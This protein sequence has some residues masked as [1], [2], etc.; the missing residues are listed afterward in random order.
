MEVDLN[1]TEDVSMY[2]YHA[3]VLAV[4]AAAVL[5]WL[6]GWAWYGGIFKSSWRTLVPQPAGQKASSPAAV[7]MLILVA[8]IILSFALAKIVLLTGQTSFSSGAFIGV[9]C[10]L[11]FLVPPI[12]TQ[13]VAETRP[14]KLF[15]INAIYWLVAMLLAGGLLAVW[16]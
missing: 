10:G 13:H 11:G 3:N 6:V 14:F 5:M 15:G 7:M 2:L 12:F 16:K 4:L 8:C 1:P 9:V